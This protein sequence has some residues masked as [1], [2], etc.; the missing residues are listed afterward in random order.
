MSLKCYLIMLF[1]SFFF[2]AIKKYLNVKLVK[3]LFK[4][5]P[6]KNFFNNRFKKIFNFDLM[7]IYSVSSTKQKDKNVCR[8]YI[9]I[10]IYYN[11]RQK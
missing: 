7:M 11:R 2:E 1:F 3:F 6:K 8:K 9:S 5:N 4:F 10:G